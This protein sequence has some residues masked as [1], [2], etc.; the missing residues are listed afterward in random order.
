MH[1]YIKT[2][3]IYSVS[4]LPVV[5]RDPPLGWC[6]PISSREF[7]GQY[8][9]LWSAQSVLHGSTSYGGFYEAVNK[10]IVTERKL[11]I[12]YL[13]II[14][15]LSK[16]GEIN[17]QYI[18]LFYYILFLVASELNIN[19]SLLASFKFTTNVTNRQ[20]WNTWNKFYYLFIIIK[21]T[22]VSHIHVMYTWKGVYRVSIVKRTLFST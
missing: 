7:P 16:E 14:S 8:S 19:A 2:H 12:A 1:Y 18:D 3:I 20:S 21:C 10:S 4:R 22:I 6:W 5:K 11:S 13:R 17:L 9:P 15:F